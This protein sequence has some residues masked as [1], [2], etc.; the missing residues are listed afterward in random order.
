M[1]SQLNEHIY[2]KLRRVTRPLR[3]RQAGI[4][5]AT[6]NICTYIVQQFFFS[7]HDHYYGLISTSC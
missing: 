4:E 7:F 2:R 6:I 5:V 3:W 1:T